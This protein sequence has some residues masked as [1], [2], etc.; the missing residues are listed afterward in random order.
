MRAR[1]LWLGI[2][3][4]IAALAASALIPVYYIREDGLPSQ[5]LW[6]SE[7]AH[8][9]IASNQVGYKWSYLKRARLRLFPA[10]FGAAPDRTTP[11]VDAITIAPDGTNRQLRKDTQLPALGVVGGNVASASVLW[12]VDGF[13]ALSAPEQAQVAETAYLREFSGVNGW[14]KRTFHP[15]RAFNE[16]VISFVIGDMQARLRVFSP[17]PGVV[18]I[19]L[20]RGAGATTRLWSS[21]QRGHFVS[22]DHYE[23]WF[24][25]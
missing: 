18:A 25:N 7:R 11:S 3:V 6:S 19:D 23:S 1:L 24:R 8:V 21:D 20:D 15:D 5:L 17:E 9:F 14:S 22:K 4:T 12:T 2:G 13:P 16:Q 10:P